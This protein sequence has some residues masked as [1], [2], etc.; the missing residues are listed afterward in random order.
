MIERSD[1]TGAPTGRC[2][3]VTIDYTNT[4][5]TENAQWPSIVP[6]AQTDR[7]SSSKDI[8]AI[9]LLRVTPH[10]VIYRTPNKSAGNHAVYIEWYNTKTHEVKTINSWGDQGELGPRKDGVLKEEDFYAVCFVGLSANMETE[11][12]MDVE[13]APCSFIF[14]RLLFW[15]KSVKSLSQSLNFKSHYH[16]SLREMSGATRPDVVDQKVL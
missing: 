8:L 16:P 10:G 9:G 3:R 2:F 13:Y 6:E 12:M 15:Q 5:D 4:E 11:E 7:R 1:E 14:T